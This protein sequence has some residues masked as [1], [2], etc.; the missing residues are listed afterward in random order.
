M[1]CY[2][3]LSYNHVDIELNLSRASPYTFLTPQLHGP[4]YWPFGCPGLYMNSKETYAQF[5]EEPSGYEYPSE[6]FRTGIGRQ[7][8]GG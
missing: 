1:Q 4:L 3:D 8:A 7:S 2:I 5:I 6:P